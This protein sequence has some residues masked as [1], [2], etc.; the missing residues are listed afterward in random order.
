M[1]CNSI[2]KTFQ[3]RISFEMARSSLIITP[4][5]LVC[6]VPEKI[7][8]IP[9]KPAYGDHFLVYGPNDVLIAL[10]YLC[11]RPYTLIGT[12]QRTCLANNTWSGTAPICV[13]GT[14]SLWSLD[15]LKLIPFVLPLQSAVGR[16]YHCRLYVFYLHVTVHK[17]IYMVT[18]S[19]LH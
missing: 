1:P 4:C 15:G 19:L 18:K 6:P 5:L 11:Y 12:P 7:C 17:N 3:H 10:Q 16:W 13:K 14:L 2:L 8:V 9:P